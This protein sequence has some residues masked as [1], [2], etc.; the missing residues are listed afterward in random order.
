MRLVCHIELVLRLLCLFPLNIGK[1]GSASRHHVVFV[2]GNC[3]RGRR[4]SP[5]V[6]HGIRWLTVGRRCVQSTLG[7][8]LH[9][10]LQLLGLLA[11]PAQRLGLVSEQAILLLHLLLKVLYALIHD[12]LTRA[13][14]LLN[15]QL[16]FLCL[17]HIIFYLDLFSQSRLN[18]FVGTSQCALYILS[19]FTQLAN[20]VLCLTGLN[21]RVIKIIFVFVLDLADFALL[22]SFILFLT[23]ELS[24]Q[25]LNL[26][27]ECLLF[28]HAIVFF[29]FCCHVPF[30]FLI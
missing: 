23:I 13:G 27:D 30:D 19:L 10:H 11:G 6:A 9:L 3:F 28:N 21:L 17:T 20:L 18:R 7:C 24:L 4:I 22:S 8:R 25:V 2:G 1:G 29:E 5:L 14:F 16:L 15:L 26:A 12:L